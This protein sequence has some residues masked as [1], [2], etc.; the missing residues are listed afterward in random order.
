MRGSGLIKEVPRKQ[1]DKEGSMNNK[2]YLVKVM[3]KIKDKKVTIDVALAYDYNV[4]LDTFMRAY[5]G[6]EYLFLVIDTESDKMVKE[7]EGYDNLYNASLPPQE[8]LPYTCPNCGKSK[9]VVKKAVSGYY[10]QCCVCGHKLPFLQDKKEDLKD[11]VAAF[12][13]V[14]GDNGE[15]EDKRDGKE[16]GK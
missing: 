9:L 6:D 2:P 14:R 7:I 4:A 16:A 10:V 15:G 3:E 8:Q 5:R 11:Y 13:K 12:F 1:E